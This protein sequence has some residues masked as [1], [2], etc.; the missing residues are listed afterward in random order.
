[1]NTETK[2]VVLP[3]SSR[4]LLCVDQKVRNLKRLADTFQSTFSA[5]SGLATQ[6]AA[7]LRV[8]PAPVFVVS[9]RQFDKVSPLKWCGFERQQIVRTRFHKFQ[10]RVARFNV[11][12]KQEIHF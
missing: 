2:Q 12:G 6:I 4:H 5:L 1:M 7:S 8:Q 9:L 11:F 10:K 3:G